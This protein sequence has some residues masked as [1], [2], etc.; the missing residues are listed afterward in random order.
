M[1]GFLDKLLGR[2]P[3]EEEEDLSGLDVNAQA[4]IRGVVELSETTVKEIMVPR[5]DV[6]FISLGTEAKEFLTK[7]AESGH[8]RLPVYH[9][10]MDNVVGVIYIKDVLR[11]LVKYGEAP[12]VDKIIRK[13]YFV[14]ESKKVDEL[15][16]EFQRRKVH[17][18]VVVD[19]YGGTSGI[20]S[21]EDVIEEI[22]GDIQDEFDNETEDILRIGDGVY[23]CDAR[24]HLDKLNELGLSLPEDEFETLGGFV[25]DLFGKIPVKYEKETC[26]NADFVIQEMVGHRIA[27]VK[28]VVRKPFD[29]A[30]DK[31]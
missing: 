2:R 14:P 25:F 8:S 26:Q 24:I 31:E 11:E 6:V 16:K 7:V 20:V 5:P 22:I 28:I 4:M 18:A 1:M 13:P 21:M 12:A 17:I 27:T 19:E 15:L 23:L 9:E 30:V 3:D 10:T 29:D